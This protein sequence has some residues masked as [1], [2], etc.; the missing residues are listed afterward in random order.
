MQ[1]PIELACYPPSSSSSSRRSSSETPSQP[2]PCRNETAAPQASSSKSRRRASSSARAHVPLHAHVPGR[3]SRYLMSEDRGRIRGGDG[4]VDRLQE[5]GLLLEAEL[6]QDSSLA[7]ARPRGHRNLNGTLPQGQW[8]PSRG[9]E[10]R[11][12][13]SSRT[14]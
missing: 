7:R 1:M 5:T 3:G 4:G 13:L 11:K 6:H 8:A 10:P 14:S 2:Q 9:A 12:P